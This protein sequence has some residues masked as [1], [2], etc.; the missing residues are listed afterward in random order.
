MTV[1]LVLPSFAAGRTV[2]RAARS[3]RP[4]QVP[5]RPRDLPQLVHPSVRRGQHPGRDGVGR[6]RSRCRPA[7]AADPLRF[8]HPADLR[9]GV[10]APEDAGDQGGRL[11]PGG[12]RGDR[13]HQPGQSRRRDGGLSRLFDRRCRVPRR[14]RRHDAARPPQRG[15]DRA[16]RQHLLHRHRYV[17]LR[18]LDCGRHGGAALYAGDALRRGRPAAA[19]VR[20]ER[21]HD[22][23]HAPVPCAAQSHAHR[24]CRVDADGD[25]L[26]ARPAAA[27]GTGL[28]LAGLGLRLCRDGRQRRRPA[29]SRSRRPRCRP[30]SR[31]RRSPGRMLP[32]PTPTTS[33]R[34][35]TGFMA[36][37]AGQGTAPRASPTRQWRP[38]RPT[39]R[40]RTRTRSMRRKSIPAAR[41]ITRGGNGT[42]APTRSR[43]RSIR[44]PR[45]PSTT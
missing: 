30:T 2:P 25:H 40:P 6:G 29:R 13:G 9:A 32:A 4:G 14:R 15:R 42:P 26:C 10:R 5:G 3:R 8:Q 18:R 24:P 22:D 33:T 7:L 38:T 45:P 34:A 31:L 23:A 21:R 43:R 28:V 16:E 44:R 19:Q 36:L 17:G 41:P 20:P 39:R 11:R 37:S 1:P 35:R 12:R 27:D